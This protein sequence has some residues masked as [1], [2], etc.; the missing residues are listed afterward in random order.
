MVSTCPILDLPVELRLLIYSFAIAGHPSVTIGTAQLAGAHSDIIHRLY[1][2]GRQP[3]PGIPEHHEP[4]VYAGY[5]APLLS[6]TNRPII[7]LAPSTPGT[8]DGPYEVPYTVHKVLKLVSKQFN[9]EIRRHFQLPR[10]LKMRLFVEY[11]YG[12]Q[13][14]KTM[15]PHLLRQVKCVYLAG[16]YVSRRSCSARAAYVVPRSLPPGLGMKY[17]GRVRP[18][19]LDQISEL[20]KDFFGSEPIYWIEKLEMRIYYPGDDS[21]STVWGDE[22]SPTVVALRHIKCAEVVIE[23]WRGRYGTGVSLAARPSSE[24]AVSTIWRKLEEGRRGQPKCG[25]WVVDPKWSEPE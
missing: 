7:P 14:C 6:V 20:M 1:N 8:L 24:R 25:S 19:S 21:Y 12:L 3:C 23:V 9:E 22:G 13:V 4:V 11:P 5:N 18:N 10:N 2:E 16:A 15:T 17:N